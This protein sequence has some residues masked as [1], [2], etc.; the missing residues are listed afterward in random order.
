MIGGGGGDEDEN[1]RDS[2][3]NLVSFVDVVPLPRNDLSVRV[4]NSRR[5]NLYRDSAEYKSSSESDDDDDND[6]DDDDDNDDDDDDEKED[7][8]ANG[9]D[10][11]L[12]PSNWDAAL[13]FSSDDEEEEE[14]EEA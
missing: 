1:E 9:K 8:D 2:P 7:L 4:P 10:E 11:Q 5:S 13:G 12:P 14:E 3:E 6:D